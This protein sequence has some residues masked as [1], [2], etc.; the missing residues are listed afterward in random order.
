MEENFTIEELE[1]FKTYDEDFKLWVEEMEK[2]ADSL[3]K[4]YFENKFNEKYL[5]DM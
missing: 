5:M 2:N 3:E 1:Y 4:E